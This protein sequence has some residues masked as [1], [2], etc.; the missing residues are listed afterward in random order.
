MILISIH[1][2]ADARA[3]IKDMVHKTP[4]MTSTLLNELR[5]NDIYLKC[6]HLQKTG[7]FK[8]RGATNKV[9]KEVKAG[10]KFL[11]AASSG[12]HGQ[13]V[14]YI[15]NELKIPASIVVPEDANQVKLN[16]IKD[17]HGEIIA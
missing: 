9:K 4:I 11:T 7:S 17:Y 10:A 16:A 8:I 6:E 3:R 1:N 13:A 12:N 14:A 2:I 15:A 5:E